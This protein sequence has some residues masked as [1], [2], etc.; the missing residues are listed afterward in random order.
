[1]FDNLAISGLV[2]VVLVSA[3]VLWFAYKGRQQD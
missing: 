2:M 1:M 3:A